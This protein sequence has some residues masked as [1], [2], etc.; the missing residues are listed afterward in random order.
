MELQG[1][2]DLTEA[3]LTEVRRAFGVFAEGLSIQDFYA[4]PTL[5]SLARIIDD[6]LQPP[7]STLLV[8]LQPAGTKTP[9]FLIHAGGGYVFFYRALATRLGTD[10]PVFGI[11]AETDADQS[12]KPFVESET[13]EEVASRYVDQVQSVQPRGP[14]LL[15][16][17][18]VGG[19]IA[20]EMAQQLTRR[21]EEIAAPVLVFDGAIDNNGGLSADERLHLYR[22]LGIADE[23]RWKTQYHRLAARLRRASQIRKLNG[24]WYVARKIATN[25]KSKVLSTSRSATRWAGALFSRLAKLT[26]QKL[27]LSPNQRT[28]DTTLKKTAAESL[29]EKIAESPEQLQQIIMQRFLIKS[30]RL[31]R[32]YTPAPFP[33]RVAVFN[34]AENGV[35][36]GKTWKGLAE[37]GLVEFD[38][39]G[40]HLDMME[41]PL[42]ANTSDLVVECLEKN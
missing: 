19:A 18:C 32:E 31:L 5:E 2:S 40:A 14:Y 7:S 24:T 41:E 33:G 21:G 38:M 35:D 42:V 6:A 11:R 1:E 23:S 3:M 8:D 26:M 34:A 30:E 9:L 36:F 17:A 12:G 20:Y 16:G 29:G 25:A 13:I 22:Q 27:R 4:S 10:R 15:G 37:G 39:P 28:H